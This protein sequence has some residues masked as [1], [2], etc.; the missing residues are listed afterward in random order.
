M[1]EHD[2]AMSH[3]VLSSALDDSA[4]ARLTTWLVDQRQQGTSIPRITHAVVE[5]AR[6]RR[7]FS[8]YDRGE[9]VLKYLADNSANLGQP[10]DIGEG[11]RNDYGR[12][13]VVRDS[14]SVQN[15]L[16]KSESTQWSEVAFLIEYLAENGWVKP[17]SIVQHY[18]QCTVTAEGHNH[19][20]ALSNNADSL[21]AFVAMWFDDSMNE[22]YR[23]G[24]DPG[25]K[26]AGYSPFRIDR[27]EFINK[28]DDEIIAEIRRSKFLVADFTQGDDGARGSVYYEAGFAQGFGLPVIFTCQT[29]IMCKVRFDTN[30]YPYIRWTDAK[31]LKTKPSNRIRAV[32][33]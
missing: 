26:D 20:A 27:A 23:N 5:N 2:V 28:I 33:K 22:V 24:F 16:A 12:F 1:M 19:I 32:I 13:I 18:A 31:D 3:F 25:I 14:K 8:A 30:H 29:D 9:R 7:P 21:Q 10:V 15:V 6:N 17:S 4:R 11:S